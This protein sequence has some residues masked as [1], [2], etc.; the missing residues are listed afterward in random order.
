MTEDVV[1]VFLRGPVAR[2]CVF[3]GINAI[4]GL[5][6]TLL[7]KS[8]PGCLC[9]R[10]FALTPPSQLAQIR[11]YNT[12]RLDIARG[13]DLGLDVF[14]EVDGR[15]LIDASLVSNDTMCEDAKVLSMFVEEDDHSLFVIEVGGDED[16]NVGLAFL[17]AE[18]EWDLFE[19]K[20]LETLSYEFTDST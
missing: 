13:G 11:Q 4:R 7:R 3:D 2:D 15:T 8:K 9:H 19:A 6:R 5:D 16:G 17:C 12:G 10:P 20:V 1:D 18:G 14:D